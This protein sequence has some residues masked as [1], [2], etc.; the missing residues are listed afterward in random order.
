[1]VMVV[2]SAAAAKAM[3]ANSASRSGLQKQV[4]ALYK[5]AL[6]A[7]QQKDRELALAQREASGTTTTA[8]ETAETN[9]GVSDNSTYV[10]VRERFRDD[11]RPLI[12]V[13]RHAGTRS[14]F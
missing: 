3:A 10:Y 14:L 5:R 12:L 2:N 9:V 6:R 8:A 1:M 7:A 11:V 4:L 13:L